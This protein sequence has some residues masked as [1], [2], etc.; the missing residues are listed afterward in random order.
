MRLTFSTVC[1]DSFQS[2]PDS[3][4]SPNESETTVALP[5]FAVTVAS[6]P[7]ARQTK[8]AEWALTTSRFLAAM[9]G[10]FREAACVGD[11]HDVHVVLREARVEQCVR[12]QREAVLD[13][14]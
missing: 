13:R 5:P 1:P 7:A 11:G 4:R 3:P 14:R 10:S 6:A 12:H 8:S 9:N 2:S